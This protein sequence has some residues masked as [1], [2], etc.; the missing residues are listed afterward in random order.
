MGRGLGGGGRT[1]SVP[2]CKVIDYLLR[3]EFSVVED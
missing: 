3:E 2:E 1:F